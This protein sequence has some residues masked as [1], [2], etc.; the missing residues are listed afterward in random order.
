M[1]NNLYLR[2]LIENPVDNFSYQ[3]TMYKKDNQKFERKK[4]Y[5]VW[6][7]HLSDSS[8]GFTP[9]G[10]AGCLYDI[11]T[12]L[13]RFGA[14]DY[15]ASIGRWLSKDPIRFEDGHTNLYGYVLQDPVNLI[16]PSGKNFIP[17]VVAVVIAATIVRQCSENMKSPQQKECEAEKANLLTSCVEGG[18]QL[19]C[20]SRKNKKC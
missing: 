7:L 9:F 18:S 1:F 13:C 2:I 11:D 4:N 3:T 19:L 20:Q 10:F 5:F 15:D 14:R 8:P 16:D 12:K 17:V 6:T